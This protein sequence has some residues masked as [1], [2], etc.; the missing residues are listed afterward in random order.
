MLVTSYLQLLPIAKVSVG[1]IA[2][3]LLLISTLVRRYKYLQVFKEIIN[4]F[5]NTLL[6]H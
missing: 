1:N 3:S 2:F 4:T 6:A 5:E